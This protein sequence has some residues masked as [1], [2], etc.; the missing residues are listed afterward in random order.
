MAVVQISKIQIRRGQ[1][2]SGTG[3]PQLA[4]GELAWAVD[5][6][7][8]YIGNGSVSEGSP[9]V[10]NT[11]VIT[12]KDLASENNLFGLVQYVYKTDEELT[13]RNNA[14]VTRTLQ[15]R[16]DDQVITTDFGT[17]GVY[18]SVTEVGDDDTDALQFAINQLF[19]NAANKASGEV[20]ASVKSRVILSIPPGTFKISNTIYIP[21]YTTLIGAGLDKTKIH[22]KPQETYLTGTTINTSNQVTNI[23][24]TSA[25]IGAFVSGDGIAAGTTVVAI[26]GQSMTISQPATGSFVSAAITITVSGPAFQFVNDF[27]SSGD[28]RPLSETL[29]VTQPRGIQMSGM[30]IHTTTDVHTC[31]QLDAVRDSLFEDLHISGTA[32]GPYTEGSRGISMAVNGVVTCENNIFRNI[33][34]NNLNYGVYTRQDIVN[35]I[36]EDCYFH[37]VRQGFALGINSDSVSAGEI[38]GPRQTQI[39][40]CKFKDVIAHAVYLR[41]GN[42][43]LVNN[44]TLINVGSDGA[45]NTDPGLGVTHYPQ[46]YF[47]SHGNFANNVT[48]DRTLDLE[49]DN[50]DIVYAPIVSGFSVFNS[51]TTRTVYLSSNEGDIIR[52][53]LTTNSSGVPAGAMSYMLNYTFTNTLGTPFQRV[54]QIVI[55]VGIDN[56]AV[57]LSDEYNYAGAD[58]LV[59]QTAI[60]LDFSAKLLDQLGVPYVDAPQTPYSL[61]L[62]Y[63]N[64][65]GSDVNGYFTYSFTAISTHNITP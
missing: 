45:G 46:I 11:K 24:V 10:G 48:S 30:G 8:L 55:S 61:L 17:L 32:V 43:N 34:V 14:P 12:Q 20:P 19:L 50:F 60:Q 26:D 49:L 28:P 51:N 6:Q 29:G 2:N 5:T 7:E 58:T 62:S 9:G 39:I 35:N 15:E 13:V 57:Q 37:D 36:F 47:G 3:L 59:I 54:G 44:P 31:L 42:G 22:Y 53:P 25:M 41:R 63:F 21:S 52:L 40:N 23:A 56:P 65:G 38:N 16:L 18:N 33:V 4:S 64:N 27:S 1:K